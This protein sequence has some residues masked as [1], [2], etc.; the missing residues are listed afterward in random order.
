MESIVLSGYDT[1]FKS[2]NTFDQIILLAKPFICKCEVKK[3]KKKDTAQC[4]LF[5]NYLKTTFE[6]YKHIAIVNGT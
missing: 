3:K 5:K 4:H 1:N 6:A 2:D